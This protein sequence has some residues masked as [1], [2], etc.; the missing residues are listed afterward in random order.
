MTPATPDKKQPDGTARWHKETVSPNH[1][2]TLPKALIKGTGK[3]KLKPHHVWLILALQL[4]QYRKH[5]SRH[6]WA[7]LAD[8]ADVDISTV[9]RWATEL[10]ALGLVRIEQRHGPRQ[11]VERTV[12]Y[13]NDRNEFYMSTAADA[14]LRVHRELIAE[15]EARSQSRRGDAEP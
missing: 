8:W 3:L 6:Y 5:P 12:G 7:E 1:F 14:V 9:R 15:K 4:E 11:G 2:I 10:K 13:R